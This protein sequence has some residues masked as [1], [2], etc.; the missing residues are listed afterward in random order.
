MTTNYK[1]LG[2]QFPANTS[3]TVLYTVPASTQAVC[4]TLSISARSVSSN[5]RV[6]VVPAGQSLNFQ[7]YICFDSPIEANDSI[8]LTLG[9]SLAAGDT[10]HVSSG[11]PSNIAF[12]LFGAEIS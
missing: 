2:Q 12:G 9:I 6:A 8:M 11:Y 4:S 7:H 5:F 1:V 10:V 3:D